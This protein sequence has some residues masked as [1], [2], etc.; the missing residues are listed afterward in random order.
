MSEL[1]PRVGLTTYREQAAWGVWDHTADLL[2][3]TYADAVTVAGGVPLLLPPAVAAADGEVTAA[4]ESAVAG[5][6]GLVVSGG[7]D[8]DPARYGASRDPQTGPERADRDSW[9]IALVRA[10][11]RRDLPLLG[12]CRGMQVLAVALGG[13]LVQHL[14][15]VVGDDSHSPTVGAHARHEVR[16]ADGSRIAEWLGERAEVATYHHQAVDRLPDSAV[17]NG[18]AEDGTVEAFEVCDRFWT[19]GVQWHPEVFNGLPLF[20]AFV[21]ASRTFRDTGRAARVPA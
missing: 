12:V 18:W 5:L 15:D 2:P 13:S 16:L 3:A 1:P 8:V 7:A 6:H 9:E 14:P 10:A 4:A 20:S 21:D 17:A 11:M 19:I